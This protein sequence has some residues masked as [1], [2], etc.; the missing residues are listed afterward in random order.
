MT[1]EQLQ[2]LSSELN[3]DPL[4]KGYSTYL[5]KSPGLVIRLLNSFTESMIAPIPSSLAKVWAAS[6]PYASIVDV[7]NT[8]DHPCRAS[9]LVVRE[10]FKA[11]DS[12]HINQPEVRTML[13]AW[14]ATGVITTEQCDAL[15][16]LA[17]QPASRAQVLGLPNI[18]E[19]DLIKLGE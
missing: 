17:M 8:V 9:C 4:K 1:P 16:A 11:S 13:D 2:I 3:E 15:L 10:T 5:L 6:G 7:S 14:V 12:I 19:Q 18:T